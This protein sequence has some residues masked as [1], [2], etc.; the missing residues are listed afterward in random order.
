M[1]DDKAIDAKAVETSGQDNEESKT[2]REL[3]PLRLK[4]L[5]GLLSIMGFTFIVNTTHIHALENELRVIAS[6][7]EAEL[8]SGEPNAE[9][10]VLVTASKEY[11]VYG[12]VNGKIEVFVKTARGGDRLTGV[13][14]F[15]SRDDD[16]WT[17]TESGMCAAEECQ[18]R[19][20]KA[21]EAK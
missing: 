3:I 15:L 20:A 16:E 14:Y 5:L 6:T 11:V 21:F 19:G 10:A 18:I 9:T 2:P 17:Q 12:K 8:I 4:I 1:T 7:K 13:D